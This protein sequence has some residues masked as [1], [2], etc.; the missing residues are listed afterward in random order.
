MNILPDSS[1]PPSQPLGHGMVGREVGNRDGSWDG[2][3]T[4]VNAAFWISLAERDAG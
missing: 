4:Q 2:H 1:V 3:E